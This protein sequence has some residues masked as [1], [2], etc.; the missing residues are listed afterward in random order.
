MSL[1]K[2]RRRTKAVA[3]GGGGLKP[4]WGGHPLEHTLALQTVILIVT[5]TLTLADVGAR[6][7]SEGGDEGHAVLVHTWGERVR[8]AALQVR[9]EHLV[10]VS[11]GAERRVVEST[12]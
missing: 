2:A 5:L 10:R 8:L 4:P 9:R 11:G 1:R 12:W 6:L 7:P 3:E